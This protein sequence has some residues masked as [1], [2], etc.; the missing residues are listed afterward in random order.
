MPSSEMSSFEI[1]LL[2]KIFLLTLVNNGIHYSDN[3]TLPMILID[4][5]KLKKVIALNKLYLKRIEKVDESLP[6]PVKKF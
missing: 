1:S 3:T 4:F 6:N 2:K 5:H